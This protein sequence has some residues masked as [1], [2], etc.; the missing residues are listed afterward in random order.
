MESLSFSSVESPW[1]REINL[2][3]VLGESS[4]Q[5]NSFSWIASWYEK[6]ESPTESSRGKSK[7]E[8]RR[9]HESRSFDLSRYLKSQSSV[10]VLVYLCVC[11]FYWVLV[12]I[13]FETQEK[14][15]F[16]GSPNRTMWVD[17]FA[18]LW[19]FS[20]FECQDLGVCLL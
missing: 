6:R 13:R 12:G 16:R 4:S 10:F 20:D 7:E 19:S 11:V 1:K 3:S 2:S 15:D 8:D 9:V 14:C 18:R 5:I 17:F